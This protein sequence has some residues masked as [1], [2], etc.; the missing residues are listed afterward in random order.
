MT[1]LTDDVVERFEA[2]LGKDAV[3]SS[4]EDLAGFADP[5]P[6]GDAGEFAPGAVVSPSS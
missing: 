6:F 2:L 5:Y 4:P 3:G 1:L